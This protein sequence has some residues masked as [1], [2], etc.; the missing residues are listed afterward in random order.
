MK[1]L[2]ETFV[3]VSPLTPAWTFR[4]WPDSHQVLK[5]GH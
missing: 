4:M 2:H 3:N 1:L 5:D